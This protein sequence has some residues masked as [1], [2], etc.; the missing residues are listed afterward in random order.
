MKINLDWII[1]IVLVLGMFFLLG[2]FVT[3][4]FRGIYM[5]YK[6]PL[7]NGVLDMLYL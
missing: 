1:K 3:S 4:L 5:I 7:D 6:L 2:L